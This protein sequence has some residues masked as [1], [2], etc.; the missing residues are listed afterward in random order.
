MKK[1]EILLV[2]TIILSLWTLSSC[3]PKNNSSE[4]NSTS[5]YIENFNDD[6]AILTY[7]EETDS[8]KWIDEN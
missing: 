1:I 5:S 3:K 7:H 6:R 8:Y 4:Q 2:G